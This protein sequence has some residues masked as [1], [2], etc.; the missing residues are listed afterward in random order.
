MTNATP[1]RWF[2]SELEHALRG[3]VHWRREAVAEIEEHL[4]E[5]L[6]GADECSE[7]AMRIVDRFGDPVEI[8]Y[9]LNRVESRPRLRPTA[10]AVSGA[11]ASTVAAALLLAVLGREGASSRDLHLPPTTQL[12]G[13]VI[14]VHTQSTRIGAPSTAVSIELSRV[15]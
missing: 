10:L 15:P 12:I 5:A 6:D 1:V 7:I 9:Q 13:T 11:I 8:A 14:A 3:D 2:L 4:L